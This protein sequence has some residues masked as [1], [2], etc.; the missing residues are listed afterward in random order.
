MSIT[1]PRGFELT[2]IQEGH[3]YLEQWIGRRSQAQVFPHSIRVSL[4]FSSTE[5]DDLLV[6]IIQ[7]PMLFGVVLT[8]PCKL[9]DIG[10]VLAILASRTFHQDCMRAAACPVLKHTRRLLLPILEQIYDVVVA[11]LDP[12]ELLGRGGFVSCVCRGRPRR[13]RGEGQS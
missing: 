11:C 13:R 10:L 3:N 9:I 5:G 8:F 6:D 4:A 1:K 7:S 2:N 12:R